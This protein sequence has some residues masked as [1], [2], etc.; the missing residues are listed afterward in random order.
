MAATLA[1]LALDS[2]L[3]D[4]LVAQVQEVTRERDDNT[5]VSVMLCSCFLSL[6]FRNTFLSWRR[7]TESSTRYLQ[8]ST[9]EPECSVS[10]KSAVRRYPLNVVG[11]VASG[12]FL[13][14]EAKHDTVLD[15]SDGDEP[16]LLSIK[17]GTNVSCYWYSRR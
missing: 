15:I 5:L 17:K 13:V 16:R 11:F 1:F 4:E 6:S 2:D 8:H 7:I 9:K 12:V 14:R 10:K 3:Q